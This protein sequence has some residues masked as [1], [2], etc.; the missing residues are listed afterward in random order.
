MGLSFDDLI[1]NNNA[2]TINQLFPQSVP[3]A[4]PTSGN[5]SD[6]PQGTFQNALQSPQPASMS[7][8]DLIP[9]QSATQDQLS[10]LP[11]KP[12]SSPKELLPD[13][14]GR[15]YASILPAS[16]KPDAQGNAIPGTR[17]WAVP[18]IARDAIH[19]FELPGKVISGQ[20]SQEQIE[21][22][23]PGFALNLALGGAAGEKFG[24]SG[25][26]KW[27]GDKVGGIADDIGG[28]LPKIG[29]ESKDIPMIGLEKSS[30]Y[31]PLKG[32]QSMAQKY[33]QALD[34]SG[35][36]YDQVD[37]VAKGQPVDTTDLAQHID[38]LIQDVK[39]DPMHEARRVTPKLQAL[40]DKIDAGQFDLS[41]AVELKKTLN[42]SFKSNRWTQN[43]KGTVYGDVGSKLANML[44]ESSKADPDFA[45]TYDTAQRDW[46]NNVNTPFRNKVVGKYFKPDD[47]YNIQGMGPGGYAESLN[48]E[49]V[50]RAQM[51]P[52]NIKTATELE[53][54]TKILPGDMAKSLSQE[55]LERQG[56]NTG[57]LSAAKNLA[58][59]ALDVRPHGIA[60][61]AK[62]LADLLTGPNLTP[63]QAALIKAAKKGAK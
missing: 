41:D 35:K 24:A 20:M 51:T 52:K 27:L 54:V 46:L 57:R 43:A 60:N 34:Q 55:V 3:N 36:L 8:D 62:N 53:A 47:Y 28:K 39:S 50:Q 16:F 13:E 22:Q 59:G 37:A 4:V 33:G 49:T 44:D 42:Q 25:A 10:P 45:Q 38:G 58:T 1:P 21:Q 56:K 29:T 5:P 19:N 6:I 12:P 32:M 14:P 17:E 18:G 63:E 15:V 61:T 11:E 23:A 40:K 2:A 9:Q 26:G 7:F 31:D 30:S 48:P